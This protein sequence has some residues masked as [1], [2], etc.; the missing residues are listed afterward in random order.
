MACP[1]VGNLVRRG[2]SCRLSNLPASFYELFD[3]TVHVRAL[4][5]TVEKKDVMR[6]KANFFGR[7]HGH[8]QALICRKYESSSAGLECMSQFLD[9]RGRRC[10]SDNSANSAN[11][12]HC[13]RIPDRVGTEEKDLVPFSKSEIGNKSCGK[14]FGILLYFGIGDLFLSLGIDH[15]L[16]RSA[17]MLACCQ[18]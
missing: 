18:R 13:N 8:M 3:A 16:A 11:S 6:R 10:P 12:V 17:G 2:Y 14:L 9:S 15:G 1:A 5:F 4:S 7:L